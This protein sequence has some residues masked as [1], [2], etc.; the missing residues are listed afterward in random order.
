M[1]ALCRVATSFPGEGG[2]AR[3][4]RTRVDAEHRDGLFGAHVIEWPVVVESQ[5]V[6]LAL[7][8]AR[9]ILIL[10]A[11]LIRP[12]KLNLAFFS[13]SASTILSMGSGWSVHLQGQKPIASERVLSSFHRQL[14][15]ALMAP[16]KFCHCQWTKA[17]GPLTR[18]GSR[19]VG[20]PDSAFAAIKLLLQLLSVCVQ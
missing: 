1:G 3:A 7:L 18:Y 17:I 20:S 9:I 19:S 10:Y 12:S 16:V 14:C 15:P 6:A 5:L 13:S 11:S 8:K 2:E 4:A